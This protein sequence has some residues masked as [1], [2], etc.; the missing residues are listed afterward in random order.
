MR[1]DNPLSSDG[2]DSP[3]LSKAPRIAART[4][5][6]AA[7]AAG[8]TLG[9]V[10]PAAA[11]SPYERGPD[12]TTYSIEASSG[13]FDIDEERVSS[14]VYG[15]GG[16]T[17]FYPEDDS[18]TYGGIVIAPGYTESA[19]VMNWLGEY[20]ASHGFVAFN[21]GTNTR[22]DQPNSRGRQ[23]EA[24]LD[25]LVE[26][27]DV[28]H[29]VDEDR[30]AAMGHSMGGGGTLA[31]AEDRPELKAAIPLTPWHTDKTWGSVRVP[32]MIIAAENDTIAPNYSHSIPFY[33]SLNW[34]TERAYVELNNEGHLVTSSRN[35]ELATNSL[36]WLKV[37]VD[38]DDRYEQFLCPA[39]S[40]GWFSP[41][42][43]Y[44]DSCPYI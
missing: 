25:Y 4:V 10:A 33:N 7:M 18:Q 34:G 36:S 43:D 31:A 3:P 9:A 8:L 20:L 29:L 37:F 5:L 38:E 1:I 22:F 2:S 13:P 6:A 16:G 42:S 11:D 41:Y 21:I 40:T 23:I 32:T 17:I 24:A 14:L 26:D 15:F 30:L 28:A 44:R 27:S 39:P 35:T 19:S 12:P